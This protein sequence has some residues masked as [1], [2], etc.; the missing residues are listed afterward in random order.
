MRGEAVFRLWLQSPRGRTGRQ[1]DAPKRN[2]HLHFDHIDFSCISHRALLCENTSG[3][4]PKETAPLFER[5]APRIGGRT[6]SAHI[7]ISEP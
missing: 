1:P 6:N 7:C 5:G 3:P 4:Q 2:M